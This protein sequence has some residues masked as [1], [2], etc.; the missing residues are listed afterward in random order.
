MLSNYDARKLSDRVRLF[1]NTVVYKV[2]KTVSNS[3]QELSLTE[4]VSMVVYK[5]TIYNH[6]ANGALLNFPNLELFGLL[7]KRNYDIFTWG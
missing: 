6:N 4:V 7:L 3:P 5:G 2:V 1:V